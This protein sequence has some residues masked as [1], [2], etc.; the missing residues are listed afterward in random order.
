MSRARRRGRAWIIEATP[1]GLATVLRHGRALRHDLPLEDALT[2]V[3]RH[4]RPGDRV[5][6]QEP[7]GY[8]TEITRAL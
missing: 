7:D 4:R 6:Q 5:W 1:G 3:R 8:R 2:Y